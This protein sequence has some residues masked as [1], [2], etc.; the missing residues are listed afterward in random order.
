MSD[1]YDKIK[2][3]KGELTRL[4]NLHDAESDLR[5]FEWAKKNGAGVAKLG[6]GGVM[7][8]CQF[9]KAERVS[10]LEL[11]DSFYDALIEACKKRIA[12]LKDGE[13]K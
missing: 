2:A 8:A 4:E 5:L 11:S 12:R 3:A 10:E 7:G 9:P 6:F 13:N 1:T